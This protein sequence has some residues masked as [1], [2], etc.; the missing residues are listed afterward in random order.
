MKR[1][2]LLLALLAPAALVAQSQFENLTCDAATGYYNSA[3]PPATVELWV[4]SNFWAATTAGLFRQDLQNLNNGYVGFSFPIPP[5]LKDGL[6]HSYS[7][8]DT[9]GMTLSGSPKTQTCGWSGDYIYYYSNALKTAPS[10]WTQNG[11]PVTGEFGL[12]APITSGGSLIS[13][14]SGTDY[15]VKTIL[16]LTMPGG[17]YTMYLRASADAL[18]GP[19]PSGSYYAVTLQ[20]PTPGL[21]GTLTLTKRVG[22][23]ITSIGSTTVPCRNGMV[24]R[25]MWRGTTIET[26]VDGVNYLSDLSANSITSGRPGVGASSTPSGNSISRVSLG[27]I[28]TIA[29]SAVNAQSIS[30]AA[31]PNRVEL[32]W[33]GAA[34]NTA[35]IGIWL[36][37]VNRNDGVASYP[38]TA[39]FTDA[40]VQ[41]GTQ[42]AYTIWAVD[43]HYNWSAPTTVTVITPP[44]NAIDPRRTGVRPDGT[45][46]GAMG[47]QIDTRSGNLNVS[48]PLFKAQGRGGWG[49]PFGLS[50][51]SQLW[52]QEGNSTDWLLGRDMG[53][54]LGWRLMAGSI[55]P[56]WSGW[57][58]IHHYVYTDSTGAEYRLDVNNS[59]I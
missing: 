50:Y 47:E 12:G 23:V 53:Y 22:G 41:P 5:E 42:Y 15:E 51:N 13:G 29:P 43:Y 30:V 36:Y 17:N 45:Y 52:R 24:I 49:V 14:T 9:G 56:Y 6:Q 28:D 25:A 21:T 4:D 7:V 10:G 35:G 18:S 31:V 38:V 16:R 1:A 33:Q 46:W 2:S 40:T 59:G 55:T 39:E 48:M 27:A 54:G 44:A 37:Q 58:T 3:A 20:N 19:T 26:Y 32:Q 57:N 34:D 11:T 8:K